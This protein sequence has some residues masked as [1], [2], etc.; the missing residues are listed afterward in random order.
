V[1]GAEGVLLARAAS[2][3]VFDEAGEVID[4]FKRYFIDNHQ[5]IYENPSPG[6]I[7]GGITTLEEKSLGAVQKG[8]RA[9]LVEVL[10]YGE[11][12]GPH[13][14]TLLEAPGNDAVSST[15]LTAAGATVILFTTGRGTPLGF[16]AP[17][18]KI[19]SN[20]ALAARKPGWIDFD[21]GVVL[22][23]QTMDA[24]ADSL[25]DLVV[26]TASGQPTKAEL[27]GEREIAIWKSGVTL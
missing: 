27:N 25:M 18:L 7:A 2:R 14:L 26:A 23:G 5:P 10:R 3:E 21:A 17:T 4:D 1:F 6:N 19:A 9:P 11:Q 13:G 15:A 8:G 20:S 22:S 12:V 24:A 16:P